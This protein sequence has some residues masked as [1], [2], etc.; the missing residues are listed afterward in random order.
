MIFT[1]R[2]SDL[3]SSSLLTHRS[4]E[5]CQAALEDVH[6]LSAI[7][8]PF[9]DHYADLV[10]HLEDQVYDVHVCIPIPLVHA[11]RPGRPP[12]LISKAQIETLTELGYSYAKIARMFGVSERTLRWR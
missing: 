8:H 6:E 10:M 5:D 4:R 11:G 12:F 7:L 9:L 2:L 1:A 3:L